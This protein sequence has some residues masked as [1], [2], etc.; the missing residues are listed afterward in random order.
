MGRVMDSEILGEGR[1]GKKCDYQ[2]RGKRRKRSRKYCCRDRA[3]AA[4][5]RRIIE[6][7]NK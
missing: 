4:I 5:A 7:W 6:Q 2:Q 1:W 3:W